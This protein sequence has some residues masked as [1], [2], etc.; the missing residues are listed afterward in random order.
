M[1]K[2]DYYD[3]LSINKDATDK[4]IKR[5]YKRL[6]IKFHPDRNPGDKNSENKFKEI[7]QAYEILSD[8]KKRSAYDQYGH[9]AFEQENIS[10]TTA[11][12]SDIFGDVFGDIFGNTRSN[13]K[14]RGAD[15][16]YI[17][18]IS[19]EE[20][21]TGVK[22]QIKIPFL[23]SCKYCKGTG[24]QGSL[25]QCHTCHGHGQ[26]QMSQGFFTVQQTC[27][28]CHGRGSFI[29]NPCIYC[30]GKGKIET[31]K[32]LSVT[33]PKGINTGDKI[34]L[35]GEGESDNKSIAGDLYIEIRINKHFLFIREENNLHC[36]LP[37]SFATAALGGEVDIPTINGII[38][39]KIPPET[40]TGRT[41]RIRNK[42]V[43]SIK[44]GLM[45]DL[46]CTVKIETPINLNN[47]QK[48]ILSNLDK[49]INLIS[50]N[51]HTPLIRNFLK[52]ITIFLRN[53][54]K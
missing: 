8:A 39:I 34:R 9:S 54:G 51:R 24:S 29:K 53:L 45:G 22:K 10:H 6:A 12:F 20:S 1:A 15:L 40:Q 37:I 49:N 42:G 35:N 50:D 18:N 47:T 27:P 25:Q 38:K 16:Q 46:L 11:D 5:A 14:T 19:L 43:P 2:K 21:I 17:I 3:I 48:N 4:E 31:N 7:K 13:R 33:I 41:F 26:I 28:R 23:Q 52:N 36:E 30:Y 44:T 32:Q